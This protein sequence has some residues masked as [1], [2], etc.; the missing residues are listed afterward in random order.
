[1]GIA[2][3]A[4]EGARGGCQPTR[5]TYAGLWYDALCCNTNYHLEHHD[6]PAVP[7]LDLPKLREIA[8]EFYDASA[9]V[10]GTDLWKTVKEAFD[11]P[12]F[13]ACMGASPDGLRLLASEPS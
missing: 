7:I 11:A 9:V 8:P 13:Y 4:G 12:D 5:S 2:A 1:M 10:S 6:F 3:A